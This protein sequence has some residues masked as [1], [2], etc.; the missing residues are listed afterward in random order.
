MEKELQERLRDKYPELLREY[1]GDPKKTA[2]AW[3]F[4]CGDGWFRLID[5]TLHLINQ[6]CIKFGHEEISVAQ[7]KEKFGQLRIYMN[8]GEGSKDVYNIIE[9]VIEQAL[10]KSK[11]ICEISG[12]TGTLC[13]RGSWCKTLSYD[14]WRK[15]KKLMTHYAYEP[16]N[17]Y[18]KDLWEKREKEDEKSFTEQ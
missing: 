16:V 12:D 5:D 10:Q 8:Y 9:A 11:S 18:M 15:S 14:E 3:G 6:V 13:K 2:M 7:V 1:G 4:E 17:V